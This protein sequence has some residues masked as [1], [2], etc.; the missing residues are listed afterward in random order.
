MTH[1][2][3]LL[4]IR[5]RRWINLQG[6]T[7]LR[8]IQREAVEP[9][10]SGNTDVIISASTAA[11]KTE[12]FF[13]PAI[14]SI[15][16]A[17][18]GFGILYI[19]PLKALINDQ[20]RRLEALCEL[21]EIDV[22]PWHG[23][24]S[25][26]KKQKAKRAPSGIILITPE[27]LESL[28]IRDPEWIR[29]AFSELKY[30]VIDEF[31]AFIGS[32]RGI[33]LQSLL[34][35]IEHVICPESP[36]PRV[37][38]SATLGNIETVPPILRPSSDF[39]CRIIKGAASGSLRL[40]VRGYQNPAIV[41][42]AEDAD[43]SPEKLFSK[44]LY[45]LCRGGSHLVFAN[46][47]RRTEILATELSDLCEKNV[48]PNEFFPH[49]GSLSKELRES[50]EARLQSE[51]LPTT[52]LCTMTLELG[53][54]IGKVNSVVQV[55][56][57]HSVASLKQ[58][59]GRSGRRG[60]PATLR[61]MIV[62]NELTDKSSIQDLLRLELI[63]S[64]AMVRLLIQNKWIEPSEQNQ[65][66]YSTFLHQV[67]AFIAQW[68]GV[69]ADQIYK[70][71]CVQGPFK[72][73][74][75]ADYFSLL[76][77]MGKVELIKQLQSGELVLGLMGE[78]LVSHYT[79]YA[80]F[81]TPEEYRIV[82]NGKSLG[83]LPVDYV[84]AVGQSMIFAGRRWKV[85][86]V[87]PERKAINVEKAKSGKPPSFGGEGMTVHDRVREEMF[88]ILRSG[89]CAIAVGSNKLHFLDS[90]A[91][92]LFEQAVAN[93]SDM[94][95]SKR[96]LLQ[97]GN[98]VLILLWKGDRVVRTLTIM[99]RKYGLD[100]SD[101]AGII[102]VENTSLETVKS[103]LST[104]ISEAENVT[105]FQLAELVEDKFIEKYDEFLP[106]DL[107]TKGFGRRSYDIDGMRRCIVNDTM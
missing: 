70:T 26:S 69:R 46:S 91:Q 60:G 68:G 4:D 35:R 100:A 6:W 25:V 40:E 90:N 52:A 9:I 5:V 22:V 94:G 17:E 53:I 63:Q 28:L 71:L 12:A 13:L 65:C 10:L 58:R 102:E 105:E 34:C 99:L 29:R 75:K 56:A 78:K 62:E 96:R 85:L 57:P 95:L 67:L 76:T 14:S 55:T 42:L 1:E 43:S 82:C 86:L 3:E 72:L 50:L 49:H 77:H 31:H 37:A 21:A 61:M 7:G 98:R 38:L 44:D 41:N 20:Y 33:H 23:D 59:V 104:I 107:L 24:A 32:E 36:I 45:S 47:R 27:S 79:F 39:P 97:L 15:V 92:S 80:V 11:G 66:H 103:C 73:V 89:E 8:D 18:A 106:P 64:I 16:G 81:K 84:P 87:D 19:S 83:S 54:D 93:F 51:S 2:V 88:S 101:F 30:V 48:V 74:E